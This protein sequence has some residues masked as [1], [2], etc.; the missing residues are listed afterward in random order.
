MSLCPLFFALA[1][2]IHFPHPVKDYNQDGRYRGTLNRTVS[3]WREHF[4]LAFSFLS[5]FLSFFLCVS[6]LTT[7]DLPPKQ[8]PC[9]A[10][11]QTIQ[12]TLNPGPWIT[13]VWVLLHICIHQTEIAQRGLVSGYT[14]LCSD[15]GWRHGGWGTDQFLFF[16]GAT[17]LCRIARALY[18]TEEPQAPTGGLVW[19]GLVLALRDLGNRRTLF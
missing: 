16:P 10:H 17:E 5:F 8:P 7:T 11:T 12:Q 15:Y 18:V 2:W 14:S 9:H 19:A 4:P 13:V 3:L 6:G 1:G